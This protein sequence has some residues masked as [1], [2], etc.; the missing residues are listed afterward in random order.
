MEIN[1]TLGILKL[2]EK[3]FENRDFYRGVT[4]YLVLIPLNFLYKRDYYRKT[5]L[6][7]SIAPNF[8]IQSCYY[9]YYYDIGPITIL[10][11]KINKKG[12]FYD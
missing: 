7:Q 12:K 8:N 11:E 9:K 2:N 5:N 3:D 10:V 1:K 4:L 6:W